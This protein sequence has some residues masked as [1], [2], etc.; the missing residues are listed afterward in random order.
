MANQVN[1]YTA[2]KVNYY[3]PSEKETFLASVE[4]FFLSLLVQLI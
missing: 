2:L 4:Y 3:Y 1:Q